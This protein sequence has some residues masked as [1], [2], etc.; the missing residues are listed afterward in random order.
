ML[1]ARLVPADGA[2]VLRVGQRVARRE[3]L[4]GMEILRTV[5]FI[6]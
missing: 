5:M 6:I 3:I 2:H 1:A 4:E